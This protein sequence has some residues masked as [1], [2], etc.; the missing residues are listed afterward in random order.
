[1][2]YEET[3]R[4]KSRILIITLFLCI[5]LR[6]IVNGIFVSWGQVLPFVIG[7]AVISG[8]LLLL[9]K[10]IKPV[11]MM[12]LMVAV[13][14][15]FSI[16]LMQFIPCTAN[17]LIFF[18]L[19]FL[20]V[21]YEDIR[22]IIIQSVISVVCFVVFFNLYQKKLSETWT[23]DTM[24]ICIVY[25]ISGC[26]VFISLSRLNRESYDS[27]QKSGNAARQQSER[28]QGLLGEIGNSLEVLKETSVKIKDSISVTN[29]ISSQIRIAGEDVAKTTQSV[30]DGT[31]DIKSKV[32]ESTEKISGMNDIAGDLK[33]L[34][35]ENAESV[36]KG[37]ELVSDLSV[38]M[39]GL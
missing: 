22:P 16:V 30:A 35:E 11:V 13:L 7:G 33:S 25:V 27:I 4:R 6:G 39:Q 26:F 8:I 18:L 20:I 37:N 28:A 38:K 12:Y 14:S 36:H 24:V 21:I 19:M 17:Y 3:L 5:A 10:K 32:K 2:T 23:V 31:V 15:A 9:V 29:N 1:M 34:S